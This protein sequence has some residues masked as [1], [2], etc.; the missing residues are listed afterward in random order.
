[1]VAFVLGR[2]SGVSATETI[3]YKN[4]KRKK[5]TLWLFTEKLADLCPVLLL[6]KCF[7]LSAGSDYLGGAS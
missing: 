4:L 7:N 5:C 6:A 1:M 2:Q 3:W